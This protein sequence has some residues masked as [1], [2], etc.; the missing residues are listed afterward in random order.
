MSPIY[1]ERAEARDLALL[2]LVVG[3]FRKVAV[4]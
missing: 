2:G 4:A 1:V 3:V